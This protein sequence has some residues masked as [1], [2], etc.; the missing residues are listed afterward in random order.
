MFIT[1]KTG[2][3]KHYPEKTA[4]I[5]RR[6][7]WFPHQ[8]TSE[9]QRRKSILMTRHYPDLG[10]VFDWLN[11]ISHSSRVIRSTN[12]IWVVTRYQY[13][14]SALFLR[15]HLAGKQVAVSPNV[16]CYVRLLLHNVFRK[17]FVTKTLC[18]QVTFILTITR[19]FKF[20]NLPIW[21]RSESLQSWA[22]LTLCFLPPWWRIFIHYSHKRTNQEVCLPLT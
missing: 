14:I 9:K 5:W 15:R 2:L 11:Q 8:M 13:G 1:K 17:N 3:F 21:G 6:Y 4:D 12:Q 10:S 7:H 19:T 22:F 16:G 20:F 18:W